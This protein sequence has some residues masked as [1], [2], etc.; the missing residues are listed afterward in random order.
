MK[1]EKIIAFDNWLWCLFQVLALKQQC[2]KFYSSFETIR[3][4]QYLAVLGN[5]ELGEPYIN[6]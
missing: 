5:I 6:D 4:F 1:D 2:E 3:A